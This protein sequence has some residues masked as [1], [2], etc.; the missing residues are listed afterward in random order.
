[1]V[2]YISFSLFVRGGYRVKELECKWE[3]S[4]LFYTRNRLDMSSESRRESLILSALKWRTK[5][6]FAMVCSGKC[7]FVWGER[8]E[9]ISKIRGYASGFTRL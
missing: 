6:S 8:K 2:L 7:L 9:K 5:F 4:G 1:M 3:C